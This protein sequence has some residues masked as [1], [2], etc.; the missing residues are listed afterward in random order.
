MELR[1]VRTL[2]VRRARTVAFRSSPARGLREE[3]GDRHQARCELG[4]CGTCTC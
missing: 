2:T 1:P 3:L 4:E